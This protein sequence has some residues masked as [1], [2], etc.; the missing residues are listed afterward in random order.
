MSGR[1]HEAGFGMIQ[2]VIIAAMI[3]TA[4]FFATSYLTKAGKASALRRQ[5][6]K[7]QLLVDHLQM[8]LNDAD[9]CTAALQGQTISTTVNATNPDWRQV[10]LNMSYGVSAG[11]IGAGWKDKEAGYHL[12][13]LEIMPS[14]R[15]KYLLA[16]GSSGDRTVTYDW[17][18]L[19]P[20]ANGFLKFYGRLRI[21]PEDA[22]WDVLNEETWIRLALAVTPAGVVHQC[23][24]EVSPAEACELNG[25]AWDISNNSGSDQRCNPDLSCFNHSV[26]LVSDAATCAAPYLPNPMGYVDGE[27]KY[28]CTWC[29]RNH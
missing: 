3:L 6:S 24:G 27:Y 11:P 26:G 5:N 22:H 29:N 7:Y 2:L 14:R 17:P 1:K 20:T 8:Q 23:F 15:A 9:I 25:G 16:D 28:L 19:A 4:A 13:S 21:V 18:A 12:R 10:Q